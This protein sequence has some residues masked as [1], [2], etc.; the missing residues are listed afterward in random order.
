L[1]NTAG[2]IVGIVMRHQ[3]GTKGKGY[4]VVWEYS[5]LGESCL[6][7]ADILEGHKEAEMLMVKRSKLIKARERSIAR[8]GSKVQRF[9]PG[10]SSTANN[11]QYMSEDEVEMRAPSSDESCATDRGD[12]DSELDSSWGI[13][14]DGKEALSSSSITSLLVK[15]VDAVSDAIDGLHWEY[16]G[17]IH[18]VSDRIM[19]NKSTSVKADCHH[20]FR[21]PVSSMMAI[22]PVVF[23]NIIVRHD[24]WESPYQNAWTKFMSKGR[25]LQITSV[26]HFNDNTDSKRD[27]LHKI[28]PLLT[29][30]KPSL[31]KYAD[32]GS[33]VSYDEATMANKS[34]YG[35]FLICFNPMKP[36][37]K[38]HFKIYMICCAYTKLTFRIKLHT[39]DNSDLEQ[40]DSHDE[41]LN[42]LDNLTLQLCKPFFNSGC[43]VNMDNNYMSTTCAIKLREK[44]VFCR[45]TIRS[46]RKFV[47]KSIFFTPT[48]ARTLP[49]GTHR[50]AVNNEHQIVAVGW[51]DNKPVHFISTSDT[52]E[53][54]EVKRRSGRESLHVSA[55]VVVHNY[56]KY[57][58]GVDCHD[59]LRSTFSL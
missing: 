44:G 45:G 30:L 47:P 19:K 52:S 58:G 24:S 4:Q 25:Y 11:L 31:G 15:D 43:T 8:D 29:I 48:E 2:H 28:R 1:D 53:I 49:R 54:V 14:A 3:K 38:F 5:G 27:S 51:L 40:E 56:N 41:S 16:N 13:V 57:M 26:L 18:N 17:V 10:S 32:H 59:R 36:T 6:P 39:K 55:P 34:S 21:S 42:K 50:I 33:E 23:W 22:F 7:L 9:R 12:F 37:G 46:N 20:F 35:H